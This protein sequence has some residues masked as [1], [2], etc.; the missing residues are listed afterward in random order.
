[1]TAKKGKPGS[2]KEKELVAWVSGFTV[3]VL[4]IAAFRLRGL[5]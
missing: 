1:V 2:A 5:P 4:L 3:V